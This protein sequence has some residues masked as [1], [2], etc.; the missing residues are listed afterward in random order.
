MYQ[1]NYIMVI[2]M[3]DEELVETT[4]TKLARIDENLKNLIETNNSGHKELLSQVKDLCSHV[5]H[6]NTKMDLRMIEDSKRILSLEITRTE[7]ISKTKGALFVWKVVAGILTASIAI[8]T[9]AQI[10]GII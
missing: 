8:L 4:S 10:L 9:I 7:N 6:E 5:N 2:G 1:F 3:A